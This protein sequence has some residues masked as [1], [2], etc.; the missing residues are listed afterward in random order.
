MWNKEIFDYIYNK[1]NP[2]V[3]PKWKLLEFLN[4]KNIKIALEKENNLLK[5]VSLYIKLNDKCISELISGN[6]LAQDILRS[7]EDSSGDNIH[8]L[9]IVSDNTKC[10]LR[11]LKKIIN[12]EHPKTISWFRA[13][14]KYPKYFIKE[15]HHV[16]IY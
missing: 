4:H 2:T 10:I 15:L 8:F 13:Y 11:G 3:L 7:T 12:S 5:C 16:A 9:A 6:K 14:K 1:I